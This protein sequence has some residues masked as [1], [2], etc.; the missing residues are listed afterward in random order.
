MK[1]IK[2]GSIEILGYLGG[3]LWV[4]AIL[5]RQMEIN[6]ETAYLLI[7]GSLPNL[8]AAWVSGMFFKWL[9]LFGLKKPYTMK[10]HGA[11]CSGVLLLALLSEFIHDG[12]LNAPFDVQDIWVTIGALMVFYLAPVVTKDKYFAGYE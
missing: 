12:F 3:L 2:F 6:G 7:L 11:V 9:V 4:A 8:G 1:K 5:L 10:F